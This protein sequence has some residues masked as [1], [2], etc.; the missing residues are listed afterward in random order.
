MRNVE[1]DCLLFHAEPNPGIG[2]DCLGLATRLGS[3]RIDQKFLLNRN[4]QNSTALEGVWKL[5]EQTNSEEVAEILLKRLS[6]QIRK[7]PVDNHVSRVCDQ[8]VG[9]IECHLDDDFH[10]G[11]VG[12]YLTSRRGRFQAE[13][14]YT[15]EEWP[16]ADH[17]PE[18]LCIVGQDEC[19]R[20]DQVP[21]EERMTKM[22][23]SDESTDYPTL[24]SALAGWATTQTIPSIWPEIHGAIRSLS[25]KL[26]D[27]V[28]IHIPPARGY[29]AVTFEREPKKVG[30]YIHHGYVNHIVPIGGSFALENDPGYWRT[31]FSSA[32]ESVSRAH[33]T[34]IAPTVCPECH[35]HVPTSGECSCGWIRS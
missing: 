13:L 20:F 8:V 35:L 24:E 14:E 19:A 28:R 22:S 27:V 6:F 11:P 3:T 4:G 5:I 10:V 7:R 25:D 29:I 12:W 23:T 34:S 31:S 2:Y 32:H 33:K 9:W 1:E 18:I 26:G 30:A 16:L 17:G 21:H 15:R